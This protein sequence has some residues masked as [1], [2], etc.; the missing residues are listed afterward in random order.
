MSDQH[1]SQPYLRARSLAEGD[2]IELRVRDL[3]RKLAAI[4][5]YNGVDGQLQG[6]KEEQ[7]RSAASQGKRLEELKTWATAQLAEIRAEAK[8]TRETTIDTKAR[9]YAAGAVIVAMISAA[10]VIIKLLGGIA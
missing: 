6:L 10:A 8:S 9:V 7:Q 5:G 2:D 1:P 3:E 4:A